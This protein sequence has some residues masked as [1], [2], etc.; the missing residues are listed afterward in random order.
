MKIL[1]TSRSGSTGRPTQT[2]RLTP[3]EQAALDEET[4]AEAC[5]VDY[6]LGE[7]HRAAFDARA[8]EQDPGIR[9]AAR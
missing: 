4:T 8:R 2:R 7:A 6:A 9:R 1:R 5:R 3:D